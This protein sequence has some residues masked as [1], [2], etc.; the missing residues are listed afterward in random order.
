MFPYMLWIH[1]QYSTNRAKVWNGQKMYVS[2]IDNKDIWRN[3][4]LVDDSALNLERIFTFLCLARYFL[5]LVHTRIK[6]M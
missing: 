3:S 5:V 6:L 2:Y 1:R 4:K